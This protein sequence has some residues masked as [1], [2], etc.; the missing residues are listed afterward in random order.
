MLSLPFFGTAQRL[1]TAHSP[2]LETFL[3]ADPMKSGLPYVH[4]NIQPVV[5]DENLQLQREQMLQSFVLS[6]SSRL[7]NFSKG[8][9]IDYKRKWFGV[10][11]DPIFHTVARYG[12]GFTTGLITGIRRCFAGQEFRWAFLA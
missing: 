2:L 10:E 11:I 3:Q 8:H 9:F 6:D 1:V 5:L 4:Y 7:H 12:T